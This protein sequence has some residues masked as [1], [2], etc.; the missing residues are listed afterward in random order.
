MG[1]HDGHRQRLKTEFLEGLL[2]EEMKEN[3][4]DLVKNIR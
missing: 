3:R 4:D 2:R 1:P